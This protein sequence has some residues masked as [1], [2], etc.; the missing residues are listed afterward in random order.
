MWSLL[1]SAWTFRVQTQSDNQRICW[2]LFTNYFTPHFYSI[3]ILDMQ[4]T[5]GHIFFVLISTIEFIKLKSFSGGLDILNWQNRFYYFAIPLWSVKYFCVVSL[6]ALFM[7][8]HS[9]K[10]LFRPP[11]VLLSKFLLPPFFSW[12]L[13]N[14]K[15]LSIRSSTVQ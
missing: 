1:I 9:H 11:Q 7:I 4:M 12:Y 6:C 8:T 13:N 15:Y 10:Q 3:S 14:H 5:I 2:I